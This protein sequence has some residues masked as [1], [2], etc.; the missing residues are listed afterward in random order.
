MPCSRRKPLVIMSKRGNHRRP[1]PKAGRGW[2]DNGREAACGASASMLAGGSG[3]MGTPGVWVERRDKPR[4][5][6][7]YPATVRGIDANGEAFEVNTLIDNLGAGG[8]FVH[9][10]RPIAKGVQ[11]FAIVRLATALGDAVPV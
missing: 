2:V 7:A 10:P 11:L 1:R 6:I 3:M 4:V 9:L 5:Q 8:L